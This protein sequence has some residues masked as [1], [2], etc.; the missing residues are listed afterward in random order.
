MFG[1]AS[2]NEAI[3]RITGMAGVLLVG[4]S[5]ILLIILLIILPLFFIFFFSSF[6][7]FF[8]LFLKKKKR[9]TKGNHGLT[10]KGII[11]KS[12]H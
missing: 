2:T 4:L 1:T 6:S 3:G 12:N 7:F 10:D 11:K 5:I 8:F 9:K